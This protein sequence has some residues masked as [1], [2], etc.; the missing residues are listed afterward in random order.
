MPARGNFDYRSV[1]QDDESL[2]AFLRAM[3]DFEAAFLKAMV[4]GSDFTLR[5]EVHGIKSNMLHCRVYCDTFQRP[6]SQVVQQE[7]R[8]TNFR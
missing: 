2:G 1:L 3:K 5:L 8:K 4:D 6:R 7:R